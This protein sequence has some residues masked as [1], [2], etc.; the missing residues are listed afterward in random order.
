VMVG[1]AL[2]SLCIAWAFVWPTINAE[3]FIR[4]RPVQTQIEL[5]DDGTTIL[6]DRI[7]YCLGDYGITEFGNIRL[8]IRGCT[9]TGKSSGGI[10]ISNNWTFA[11]GAGSSGVG[12]RCFAFK[13]IPGGTL[14]TFGGLTLE[15]KHGVLKLLGKEFVVD[16]NDRLI[17]VDESGKIESTSI[18]N[19]NGR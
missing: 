16:G 15:I 1:A 14:C 2:T 10:C 5:Q 17:I 7:T 4:D 3:S 18:I 6:S 11:G 13:E 12:N 8:A 9:F 19:G